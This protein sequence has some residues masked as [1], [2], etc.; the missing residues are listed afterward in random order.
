MN[1]FFNT[2]IPLMIGLLIGRIYTNTH[3]EEEQ[4]IWKQMDTYLEILSLILIIVLCMVV[5]YE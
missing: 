2:I 3:S 5:T 4:W 1:F